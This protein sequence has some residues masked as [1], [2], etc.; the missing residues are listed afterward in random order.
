MTRQSSA[1]LAKI[2]SSPRE[3]EKEKEKEREKEKEKEKSAKAARDKKKTV[4]VTWCLT[5]LTRGLYRRS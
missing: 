3:K 5:C 1:K 2:Q 4:S